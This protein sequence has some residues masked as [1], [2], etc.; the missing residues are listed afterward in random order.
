MNFLSSKKV[1]VTMLASLAMLN[2]TFSVIFKHCVQG[3]F[4]YLLSA[5]PGLRRGLEDPEESANKSK[6]V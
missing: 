6:R 4:T 2:E 1:N 3:E 5:A